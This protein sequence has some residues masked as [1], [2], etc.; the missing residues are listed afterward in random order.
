MNN[1]VDHV[2]P[3][4]SLGSMN[5]KAQ[6]TKLTES[7][8][9][10]V[11]A[12]LLGMD[13]LPCTFE[14]FISD[15]YFLGSPQITNQGRSIFQ[16]WKDSGKEIYPTP[17]TTKTPY[18]SFGGCIGSGKSTMAKLMGLYTY[19]RLDCCVDCL[20]SLG[21]AGG[22]KLA[23]GFFHA[24]EQTAHKDFVQ[25]FRGIFD[26]SPYF[27]NL[28]HNPAIRFISSGPKAV[29]SVIGTQLIFSV[30]S[31]IGFWKPSDAMSKMSETLIRYQ[32]RFISKR[33]TFGSVVL[34]SSAKDADH[35]VA[36]KFEEAV[37][38]N[39]LYLAKFSHW[40]ARPELYNESEGRTFDFYRGDSV[41]S[42]HVI[43]EDEDRKELDKD[44][45]ISCPLQVKRNFMLDP[46]RSLQDLAGF[47][48]SGKELFFNGSISHLVNCSSIP[49]LCD[50][51]IKDIDF[52]DLSDSLYNR[53]SHMLFRVPK[54]LTL[55][56]HFDIGLVK[57]ITGISICH[58]D[59]EM[60]SKDKFDK[61]PYPKFR[62]PIILGL[63][64]K[65]GQKTSLDHLFQ[66]VQ[67]L[68]LD[69]DIHV[70][71]DGFASAG[72]FQS[73]ERAGIKYKVISVDKT[74][75]PYFMFKNIVNSE[76]ATMVYNK[77]LLREC[78][79]LKIVSNGKDG[80]HIKIDHP[81]F[82]SSFEFDYAD[83]VGEK[84]GTKD[85]ADAVVG[86][87]WACYEKY[88]EYLEE[89]GGG[90]KKQLSA[91]N[92]LYKSAREESSQAIQNML[93]SIF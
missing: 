61:T 88:S 71:A 2:D 38:E 29:G 3:T 9:L 48:Y 85:I 73:C 16:I 31:E 69:Y 17:I 34:D 89:G 13:H 11:G 35:S 33:F 14:Q 22:V 51:I 84:P 66:L 18:V 50:D 70:S 52:F 42:P 79:E 41:R 56:I 92:S 49:N 78:S 4:K 32:S 87:L 75:E 58:Y 43:E 63:S 25:Y 76:R 1:F 44:R 21:L 62:F 15:D 93:E 27:K 53:I 40:V 19:H 20:R 54:G 8:K 91:I 86:S 30:L 37:P 7:E 36:D 59:G 10:L 45:I 68:S 23:F 28:Y 57:D 80:S 55:F 26:I 60:I 77:T 65:D 12:K 83:R 46:I 47:P 5:I 81:E 82:S 64:R 72:L 90:V 6:Y 39:E 67:R 24:N 74:T